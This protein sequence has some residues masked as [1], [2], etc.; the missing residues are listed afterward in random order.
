MVIASPTASFALP[1]IQRGLFAAAGGLARVIRTCGMQLGSELA[2]TGKRLSPQEAR[3]LKLINRV[4][5][6]PEAVL[7]DAIKLAQAVASNSPDAIIV[8]RYGLREAWENGSVD[9]ASRATGDKY[10]DAL[11]WSENLQ[12]GLQAFA[13]KRQPRWVDSKL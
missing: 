7:D 8:T 10:K 2:L 5:K 12:I 4:S 11:L 3:H 9:Q 1:E 13:Q 6:T